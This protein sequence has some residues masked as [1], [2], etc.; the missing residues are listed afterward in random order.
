MN[1]ELSKELCEK[2]RYQPADQMNYQMRDQMQMLGQM[3]DQIV[4]NVSNQ[5]KENCDER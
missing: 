4:W 3:W 5:L 2:I 1:E